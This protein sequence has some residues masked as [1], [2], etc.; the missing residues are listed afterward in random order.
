[1]RIFL[2]TRW[3]GPEARSNVAWTTRVDGVDSAPDYQINL[4]PSDLQRIVGDEGFRKICNLPLA[5]TQGI[6][7][8]DGKDAEEHGYKRIGV[9]IREYTKDTRPFIPFHTD[10]NTWTGANPN[11]FPNPPANP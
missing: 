7:V 8:E 10:L 6:S 5:L 4:Y 9:F 1:M 11:P 2:H 3:H